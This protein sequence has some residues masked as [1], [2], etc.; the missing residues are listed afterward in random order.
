MIFRTH[1]PRRPRPDAAAD[2]LIDEVIELLAAAAQ[3]CVE[4]SLVDA[5]TR[6]RWLASQHQSG[7]EGRLLA[8]PSPPPVDSYLAEAARFA[9]LAVQILSRLANGQPPTLAEA[10]AVTPLEVLAAPHLHLPLVHLSADTG[11]APG[12]AAAI[13][14]VNSELADDHAR[15]NNAVEQVHHVARASAMDEPTTSAD[16]RAVDPDWLLATAMHRYAATCTWAIAL[17]SARQ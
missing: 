2:P 9:G 5:T 1:P 15:L 8:R 11:T 3:S 6:L 13:D 10:R 17:V 16:A 12:R 14:A 7:S 4:A